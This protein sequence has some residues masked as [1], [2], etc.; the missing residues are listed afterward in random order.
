MLSDNRQIIDSFLKY[1]KFERMYSRET[2]RAYQNDLIQFDAFLNGTSFK[3]TNASNIQNFLFEITKEKNLSESTINR[4]LASIKSFYKF[5]RNQKLIETNYSKLIQSPK[6]AKRI[7]NYMS[8]GE[9]KK[10]LD[11]PY[12]DDYKTHRD[13]LVLELFYATGIR[14]SEL[15]TLRLP[16]I[17]LEGKTIKVMGKG[18]KERI[19]VFGNSLKN[20]LIEYLDKRNEIEKFNESDYLFPQNKK[21]KS[22]KLHSHLHQ[23]TI[24]NIVKKYIKSSLADEKLSPHSLRHSFAT[25]LL[26]NG[27]DIMSV[28]ELLGHNSLSST[29]IYTHIQTKKLKEAYNQAHPHAK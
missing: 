9:I 4:K 7:P 2:L 11:Y 1:I 25:H 22:G 3:K 17:Q 14:I 5:L 26:N 24:Y 13:R 28:K 16:Q 8:E 18:S 20:I 29:Q 23:K 10:L 19:V 15:T 21:N 12:G 6:V 27:A